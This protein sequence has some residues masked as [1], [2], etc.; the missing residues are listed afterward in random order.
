MTRITD[1][2][3]EGPVHQRAVQVRTFPAGDDRIVVEGELKD[4]RLVPGHHWDGGRRSPGVI[5]NMI[6]RIL[7]GDWPLTILDAEAEMPGIPHE[8]CVET[9]D[10]VQKVIGVPIVAGYSEKIR[11]T[12]GGT[13]GC[14]H[15]THLLVVMGPAALHGYW[16]QAARKPR[17]VPK[18]EDDFVSLRYLKNSCRLWREDGPIMEK[19]R[20]RIAELN[21]EGEG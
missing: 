18:S 19:I 4:D 20:A 8:Q 1:M 21:P 3:A 7:V 14:A 10:S 11:H 13:A 9:R 5:H 12:L 6:V 15:M 17:P 2:I 16:N